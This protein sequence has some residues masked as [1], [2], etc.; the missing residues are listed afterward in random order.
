[1]VLGD[2]G[3]DRGDDRVDIGVSD[4]LAV[5][6]LHDDELFG[7]IRWRRDGEGRPAAARACRMAVLHRGLDV[8]GV[9]VTAADD[10]EIL[11]PPRDE[12]LIVQ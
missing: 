1:M 4:P 6:L 5:H 7:V 3:A 8:F 12:R 2:R 9:V 11:E 10:D